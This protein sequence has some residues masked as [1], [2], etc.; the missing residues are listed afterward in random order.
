MHATF[1]RETLKVSKFIQ[2]VVEDGYKIPFITEPTPFTARNNKS[3]LDH[4]A[5]VDDALKKLIL[6]G[7]VEIVD[8]EPFCCNPLT[9]A[10]G[11]EKLRL[12]L[13]LRHVNEHVDLQSFR[14]EDLHTLSEMFEEGD[15]FFVFDL[16]SGYFWCSLSCRLA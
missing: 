8:T 11:G 5:F 4:R 13:D 9:V 12:V 14:H 7:C 2:S 16:E 6:N 1:W 10:G 3:S 15:F